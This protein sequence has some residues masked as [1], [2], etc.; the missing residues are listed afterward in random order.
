ME[1]GI[2]RCLEGVASA[3]V[4]SAALHWV[5]CGHLQTLF[6]VP[7]GRPFPN[8]LKFVPKQ[9]CSAATSFRGTPN[10]PG[11]SLQLP[12]HQA[13]PR[14]VATGSDCSRALSPTSAAEGGPACIPPAPSSA[15]P[16]LCIL[17][18]ALLQSQSRAVSLEAERFPPG[19]K[20]SWSSTGAGCGLSF[21]SC[22]WLPGWAGR[23]YTGGSGW[24]WE[25]GQWVQVCGGE[26]SPRACSL[27]LGSQECWESIRLD[28][29]GRGALCPVGSHPENRW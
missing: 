19:V 22:P 18:K 20:W 25:T 8:P 29:E 28:W 26:L 7:M 11:M 3:L 23:G 9:S 24:S 4:V 2:V 14:R 1:S 13:V 5:L 12:C 15:L 6:L 27:L 17:A 21:P 10:W 16:H